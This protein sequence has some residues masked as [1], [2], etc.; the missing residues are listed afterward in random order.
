[1]LMLFIINFCIVSTKLLPH[2]IYQTQ[3]LPSGTIYWLIYLLSN[4]GKSKFVLLT[5][6]WAFDRI[7][8]EL[9]SEGQKRNI[10]FCWSFRNTLTYYQIF[11]SLL[12]SQEFYE[13]P[14]SLRTSRF[15]RRFSPFRRK[16]NKTVNGKRWKTLNLS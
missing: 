6:P 2:C 7:F 13:F 1:M 3:W 4:I 15:H 10:I 11:P 8:R 12:F 14:L 9:R 5:L 16:C